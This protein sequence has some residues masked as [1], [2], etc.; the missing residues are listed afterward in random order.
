MKKPYHILREFCKI[1]LDVE[2]ERRI[3]KRCQCCKSLFSSYLYV[4]KTLIYGIY[5]VCDACKILLEKNP[6]DG[7][8]VFIK[9]FD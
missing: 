8:V 5:H 2:K 1:A 6:A 4:I 7:S 9:K 3:M